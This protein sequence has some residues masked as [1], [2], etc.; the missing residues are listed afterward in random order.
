MAGQAVPGLTS[1]GRLTG[2]LCGASL[3][4]LGLLIVFPGT[5]ENI[6][7]VTLVAIPILWVAGVLALTPFDRAEALVAL[8]AL[9]YAAAFLL[10]AATVTND[11][12]VDGVVWG[13]QAFDYGFLV[14]PTAWLAN[15][16][17]VI[18]LHLRRG[19]RRRFA[20]A[21]SAIGFSLALTAVLL[22]TTDI[23]VSIG[24]VAWAAAPA[25]LAIALRR[26]RAAAPD[27]GVV[28]EAPAGL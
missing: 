11:K 26:D 16:L 27:A 10:P 17:L 3:V 28:S 24:F 8:A 12:G 22:L 15:P 13:F 21:V 14:V 1:R 9:L 6:Q 7:S 18:A 5:P 4:L 2:V 19:P 23:H 25:I 20:L